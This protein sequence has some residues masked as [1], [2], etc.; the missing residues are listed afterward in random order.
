MSLTRF[1]D[2]V[3]D[4]DR[5]LVVANRTGPAVLQRMLETA[6]AE[7]PV[8]VEETDVPDVDDDVVLLVEGD[9]VVATSPFSALQETLLFVNSDLYRTGT[10]GIETL[11]L[12]DV[13]T[14]LDGVRFSLRSYPQSDTEKLL[15][16]VISRYIE[17]VSWQAD[18]GR[19]RASF[20][21]LSRIRDERGT[22]EVYGTL[23][24]TG[25]DVHVYGVPN[26]VPPASLGVTIHGGYT[27]DFTD[28]WFVLF[29]PDED[30]RAVG[31]GGENGAGTGPASNTRAGSSVDPVALL[32]IEQ[33]RG[34]WD[35]FWTFDPDLVDDIASYIATRL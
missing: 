16:I 34:L 15:L 1:L 12:P 2:R 28:S 31:D 20:Q 7:Q 3:P 17:R 9:E 18:G 23:G 6:F 24:D 27:E 21:S 32:A 33:E 13:L 10:Q 14:G 35:G 8:D 26:W 30:A 29:R 19:H 22:R 11:D 5:S 25:T 4:R